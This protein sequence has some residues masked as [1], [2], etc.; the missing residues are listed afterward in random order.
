MS[1]PASPAR[2][3]SCLPGDLGGARAQDR[4]GLDGGAAVEALIGSE[5][6]GRAGAAA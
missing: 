1:C 5:L 2:A 4:L 6:V 3:S